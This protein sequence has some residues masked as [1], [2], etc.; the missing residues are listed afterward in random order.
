MNHYIELD[1]DNNGRVYLV[2]HTGSRNLGVQV[3]NFYQKIAVEKSNSKKNLVR[4]MREAVIAY[5]KETQQEQLISQMLDVL[6]DIQVNNYSLDADLAYIE[7]EYLDDYLNDMILCI[8]WSLMNHTAIANALL[9][10]Y[11]Y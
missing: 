5:G 10:G 9:E 8:E 7:G 4:K 3:C 11:P 6:K 2:V 1:V